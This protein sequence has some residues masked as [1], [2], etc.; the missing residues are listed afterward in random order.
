MSFF[1]EKWWFDFYVVGVC[2]LCPNF[3]PSYDSPHT[4]HT[5]VHVWRYIPFC[6]IKQGLGLLTRGSGGTR[7]GYFAVKRLSPAPGP[8][9]YWG[10][11]WVHFCAIPLFSNSAQVVYLA[12]GDS[13]ASFSGLWSQ[14]AFQTVSHPTR[15]YGKVII[16]HGG[17]RG[18]VELSDS[19]EGKKKVCFFCIFKGFLLLLLLLLLSF[20]FFS[21]FLS[22]SISPSF[23]FPNTEGGLSNGEII[24]CP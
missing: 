24:A 9:G 22:F 18:R 8:G 2:I 16:P 19:F 13:P 20:P 10:R 12:W 3:P 4:S 1:F 11:V 17:W 14:G 23:F 21:F 7:N 6:A 15:Y 5:H